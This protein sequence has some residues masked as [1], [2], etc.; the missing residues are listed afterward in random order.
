M[1]NNNQHWNK[2]YKES[3]AV[4]DP[5]SFALFS[6]PKINKKYHL[7][8]LGCG[9]GRDSL[10]FI[11]QGIKVIACD[12]AEEGIKKI[13]NPNFLVRDFTNL[14]DN[15]FNI[16]IGTVYS[17]FTLHAVDKKSASRTLNWSYKNLIE[18]GKLLI[19]VRSVKDDF[20]GK[21]TKVGK[22]EYINDHY[23]RFIRNEELIEELK[24][25]G[26]KIEENIESKGL[27]VYKDE[28][29]VVIRVVASKTSYN[30]VSKK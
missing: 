29:P 6:L 26:F 7:I 9:N 22:D 3:K 14:K 8:E 21:G 30:K 25:I 15:E 10:F 2:F 13:N 18:N 23:R 5:S 16:K 24:E 12:L 27:A 20:Y 17:R 1:P 4:N 11:N 19:E 28:D